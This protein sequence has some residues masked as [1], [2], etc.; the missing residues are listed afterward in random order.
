MFQGNDGIVRL[1][2]S[3]LATAVVAVVLCHLKERLEKQPGPEPL[4]M[5][6]TSDDTVPR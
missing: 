4:P 5:T 6:Q 3:L 2:V 1:I